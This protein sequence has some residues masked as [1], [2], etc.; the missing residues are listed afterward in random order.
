[1]KFTLPSLAALSALVFLAACET[2][3]TTGTPP[4][5]RNFD[6]ERAELAANP[7]ARTDFVA[8]CTTATARSSAADISNMAVLMG[9]TPARAPSTF[10]QRMTQGVV[11]GRVSA[12]DVE[13]GMAGHMTPG[14]LQVLQAR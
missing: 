12:K 10:C 9:T 6:A 8:K 14:V 3:P 11:D 5:T 13:M 7:A 4:E 1:M 2:A